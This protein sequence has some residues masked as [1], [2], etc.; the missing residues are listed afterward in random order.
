MMSEISKQQPTSQP[1]SD[2]MI[3]LECG[4]SDALSGVTANP[5]VG[6]I[7][8]WLVCKNATTILS[9]TTELIGAEHLMAARCRNESVANDLR[10]IIGKNRRISAEMLGDNAHVAIS[11]GNQD[12]G[13]ST[14]MEKSLGCVTKGGSTTIEE[15]VMFG[16]K[17]SR[18][19]L[20]IMDTPGYDLESISGKAAGGCQAMLFTSGRG[21]PVGNSLAPTIKIA[22]N[23]PLWKSMEDDLDF[24][25]GDIVSGNMIIGDSAQS[26]L[27]LL[28]EI[29]NGKKCKSE[30]NNQTMF[31]LS[32]TSEA[33]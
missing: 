7:S 2:L 3:G 1:I 20:I 29:A 4:G 13:L 15:I 30:I 32:F 11:P 27:Y 24:N 16:Q 8:D 10:A 18:R 14:I 23:T 28:M 9:E 5:T 19:G 26:L 33:L 21:T 12:G 25:C 22:S 31:A 17:P 6:L